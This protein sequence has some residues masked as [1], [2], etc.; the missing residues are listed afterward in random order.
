M[1]FFDP[2]KFSFSQGQSYD[3]EI[4][5]RTYQG[6]TYAHVKKVA[7]ANGGGS[8]AAGGVDR[9]WMP[10]V[11]NVTAH[12]IEAGKIE[13]PMQIKAWAAAAKTAAIEID[14]VTAP[15]AGDD[16]EQPPF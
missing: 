9:W 5:E 13:D 3:L 10:F 1:Y 4:E 7:S 11:S 8:T 14:K 12:A 15:V 16:D 6:K 2:A